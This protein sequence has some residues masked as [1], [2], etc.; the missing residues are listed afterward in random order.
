MNYYDVIFAQQKAKKDSKYFNEISD[1]INVLAGTETTYTPSEM[2]P[3]I[4]DAIPTE[5]ASGAMIT[6]DDAANYPAESVVTTLE[7]IQDLHGYDN[8][9]AGGSGK[10]LLEITAQ[11]S[12]TYGINSTV[13]ENGEILLN[14]TSIALYTA[15]IGTIKAGTYILNGCPLGGSDATFRLDA[16]KVSD[17]TVVTDA[18]DYGDGSLEFTTN[19]PCNVV[20]RVPNGVTLQNV[21]FKPMIRLAS[22]TDPTFE[23]YSNICPI[24]G[25][26]GV[27]L[28]HSGADT[29]IYETH[30]ITFPQE[31]S[32]VYGCEVD[33][34]NGVLR[35]TEN[36]RTFDGSDDEAW[37]LSTNARITIPEMQNGNNL[38]GIS[39]IFPTGTSRGNIRFGLN[40]NQIYLVD[41][42]NEL[43]ISTVE[44]LKSF[45]AKN[46]LQVVCPLATPIEIPLT[47]EVITLLKGDNNIWTDSGTSEIDYKVDLQT[48]IQ[49]LINE[50][51]TLNVS[52]L[53]G[54]NVAVL[55]DSE[56]G[57]E[58]KELTEPSEESKEVDDLT[59]NKE[60]AEELE[61]REKVEDIKETEEQKEAEK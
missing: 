35:V 48:Y 23:P 58:I 32:P 2:A 60:I 43:G 61:K 46:P 25:H 39:N 15:I 31:Q 38:A 37:S 6:I 11:S 26:T 24:T 51:S 4:I 56:D 57:G 49:K 30:S 27:E 47:P 9:W 3:A 20:I 8:P 44:D 12:T 16:R 33:W 59:A 52:P 42:V 13:S 14:G 50:S 28:K 5:T 34:V 53:L 19:E 10:N 21:L 29:S 1:A 7:P 18:V 54:K 17:G 36:S 40:N 45:L 55:T 22:D 41:A